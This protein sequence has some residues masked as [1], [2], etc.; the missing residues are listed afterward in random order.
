[1]HGDEL[2]L[3]IRYHVIVI[4]P[5]GG[6][7]GNFSW[8][9]LKER[10]WLP[11]SVPYSNFLSGM[12]GFR[13]SKA[14]LPAGYDVMMIS[15]P[16]VL[17][18]IFHD[19]FWKCDYDFLIAFHSKFLS[20]MHGF[21]DNEVLLQGGYDVIIISPLGGVLH[22]FCW[23]NLKEF[24]NHSSLTHFAYLSPFRSYSTFYFYF[25]W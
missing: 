20:G 11:H 14:L 13:Y 24:H 8:W 22:R 23:R 9:I 16:G 15:P 4:S 1:M 3:Q 7:L 2:L 10:P 18:A 17:H 21:R 6:A 12:H 25:G 5:S 19:G